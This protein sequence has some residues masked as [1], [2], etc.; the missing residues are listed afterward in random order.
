MGSFLFV[1]LG[2]DSKSYINDAKR[3]IA[4]NDTSNV[5]SHCQNRGSPAKSVFLLAII[6]LSSIYSHYLMPGWQG[7]A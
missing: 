4:Y 5:K 2:H 7:T 6:D 3:F 1:G